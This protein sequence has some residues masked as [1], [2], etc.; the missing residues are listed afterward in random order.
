[1]DHD[2][3]DGSSSG[4]HQSAVFNAGDDLRVDLV[5]PHEDEPEVRIIV[6]AD[7]VYLSAAAVEPFI[8]ALRKATEVTTV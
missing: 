4:V 1:M 3:G 5:A 6:G 7:D 8:E 2:H